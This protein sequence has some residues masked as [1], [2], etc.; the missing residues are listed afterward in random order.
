MQNYLIIGGSSGIGQELAN[1]LSQTGNHIIATYNKNEPKNEKPD[2]DFHHLNV[3]EETFSLDFLPDELAGLIYCPGSINLKPFER[4]KP[5]DFEMDYK[6]QVIGAIKIIQQVL[7]RLKKSKN[8]SIV[9]FSTVAVQTGLPFHTQVATS[10][11]AI[12]GLAKALAAEF[13]PA[14]RVNCIAPSLTDTP[15]AAFLLNTEQKKEANALRHPLKRIGS[16]EDIANMAAFLLSSKAAW[17]TGQILHVD[18]GM[19]SLKI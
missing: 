18:G 7:P 2:I 11:G 12:E 13:A 8:A 15:L 9:L 3:L 6:L 19:S 17:I 14:I 4:I 5:I 16:T 1:Q 10:K